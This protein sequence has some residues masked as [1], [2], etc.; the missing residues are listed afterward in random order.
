LEIIVRLASHRSTKTPATGPRS[1]S[2]IRKATLISVSCA[3]V[4]FKRNATSLKTVN[5]AMK[6]P[7]VLTT[8]AI[9]SSRTGRSAKTSPKDNC[10]V[11]AVINGKWLVDDFR[12]SQH[13]RGYDR[14]SSISKRRTDGKRIV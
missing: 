1:A 6:S 8:C 5:R 10:F 3:G 13:L 7:K 14:R 12:N 9:Q 2:G 4:A 11:S